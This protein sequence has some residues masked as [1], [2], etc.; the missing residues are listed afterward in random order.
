M[1]DSTTSTRKS[2]RNRQKPALGLQVVRDDHGQGPSHSVPL[3]GN[4]EPLAGMTL[5]SVLNDG[6]GKFQ[7]QCQNIRLLPVEEGK[8]WSGCGYLGCFIR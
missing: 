2:R 6:L 4:T 3:E 1:T 5:L 7:C 8:R